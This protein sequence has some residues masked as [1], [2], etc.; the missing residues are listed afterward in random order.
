MAKITFEEGI[1]KY[2][3][4]IDAK[5]MV[6]GQFVENLVRPLMN[7]VGYHPASIDSV[8]GEGDLEDYILD[9]DKE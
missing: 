8:L 2:S 4:E 5:D 1:R 3:I 9:D 7:A 6:V